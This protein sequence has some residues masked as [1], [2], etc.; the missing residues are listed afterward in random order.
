MQRLDALSERR[1]EYEKAKTK[2]Q[3]IVILEELIK[4]LQDEGRPAAAWNLQR[5]VER[6]KMDGRVA[7]PSQQKLDKILDIE[8]ERNALREEESRSKRD[9]LLS[10]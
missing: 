6:I 10:S 8:A 5:Q 9:P 3:K 4:R 1:P 2:L 7:T